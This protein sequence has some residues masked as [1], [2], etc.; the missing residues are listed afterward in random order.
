MKKIARVAL[1]GFLGLM[2]VAVVVLL[3]G[4]AFP[5]LFRPEGTPLMTPSGN[6]YRIVSS[7]PGD[8]GYVVKFLVDEID[9][10]DLLRRAATDL[11]AVA[12][13]NA[14]K[15]GASKIVVTAQAF[16]SQMG[17]FIEW[18]EYSITF[19]RTGNGWTP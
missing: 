12:G 11:V 2:I 19:T 8:G 6:S 16:K 9:E 10:P 18:E 14:E 7:G 15:A 4:F 1:F 13:P 5:G 17:P 3:S